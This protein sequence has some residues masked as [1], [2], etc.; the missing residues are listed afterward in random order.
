MKECST[1]KH[2][3]VIGCW[4]LNLLMWCKR[5]RRTVLETERCEYWEPVAVEL[6]PA[7]NLET[8]GIDAPAPES[9]HPGTL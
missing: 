7:G 4:A 6:Q 5:E 3:C 8:P 2:S 1:C 9:A